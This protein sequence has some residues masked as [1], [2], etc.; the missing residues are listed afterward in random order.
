MFCQPFNCG[1][2][3]FPSR[4][5]RS[6]GSQWTMLNPSARYLAHA[7]CASTAAGVCQGVMFLD[8]RPPLVVCDAGTIAKPV[9][10]CKDKNRGVCGV[11]RYSGG[12]EDWSTTKNR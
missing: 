10:M 9:A 1:P 2:F 3:P 12:V 4:M 11:V 5:S 8:M 6:V 7:V